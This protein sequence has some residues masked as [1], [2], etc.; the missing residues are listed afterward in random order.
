MHTACY[1]DMWGGASSCCTCWSRVGSHGMLSLRHACSRVL[2]G[3][4][5]QGVVW[6][7]GDA[8]VGAEAGGSGGSPFVMLCVTVNE[9][10][11][12]QHRPKLIGWADL[13]EI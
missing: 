4:L 10:T 2:S 11:R 8:T 7:F 1:V 6:A 3:V 12:D 5:G 9:V 13:I